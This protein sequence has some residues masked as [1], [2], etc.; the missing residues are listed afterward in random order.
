MINQLFTYK[1]YC[2]QLPNH[3]LILEC[4]LYCLQVSSLLRTVHEYV[5][6]PLLSVIP[7]KLVLGDPDGS[8]ILPVI[9]APAITLVV[10]VSVTLSVILC[11]SPG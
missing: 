3:M 10:L 6:S 8:N 2:Q 1:T 4:P 7:S 5:V 9:L 11:L